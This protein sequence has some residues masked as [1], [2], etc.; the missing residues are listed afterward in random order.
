MAHAMISHI[1]DTSNVAHQ[2]IWQG[3]DGQP[4]CIVHPNDHPNFHPHPHHDHTHGPGYLGTD[5]N[6][7]DF[8][9]GLLIPDFGH[10]GGH[11]GANHGT[12]TW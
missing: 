11:H 8:Y 10:M 5:A 4:G 1:P 9:G 7:H 6:G 2:G 3:H 12:F